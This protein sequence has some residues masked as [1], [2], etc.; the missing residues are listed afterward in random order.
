M[1]LYL[2]QWSFKLNANISMLT[3]SHCICL[4]GLMFSTKYQIGLQLIGL[5]YWTNQ[6]DGAK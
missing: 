4:A 2:A 1:S 6:H 5:Q 3:L